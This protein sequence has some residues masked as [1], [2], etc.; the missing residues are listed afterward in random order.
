MD[1]LVDAKLGERELEGA[2]AEL[3]VDSVGE[4]VRGCVKTKSVVFVYANEFR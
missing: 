1:V 2:D 4:V 3:L